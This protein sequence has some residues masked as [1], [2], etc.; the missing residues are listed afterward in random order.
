MK[1]GT[2]LRLGRIAG[3]EIGLD[4][5]LLIIFFL[6]TFSLA[7]AV[8]PVWHPA[9]SAA[10][11]W[12]T[13]LAAA[14][15]FFASVLAHELSHALMGRRFGMQIRR[16]TL[17][18][19]GGM[20]HLE[21]EPPTWRAEMAMALVGPLTSL[22]L[23]AV[24]ILLGGTLAGSVNLDATPE[25]AL[26]A[27]DPLPTLLL[28]LGPVNIILGLFNLVP[29]FP[30][31][32]GRALRAALW[33]VTGSLRRATRWA[34][35]GGRAFAW[36]LI[37]AGVAM[38]LGIELPLFGTGL[39]GGLWLAFIGWFLHNAA[40]TSYRQLLLRESLDDVPVSR[41]ML[42][43]LVSVPPS[44]DLDSLIEREAAG[45]GQ[46]AFPV[47]EGGR[48]VGLISLSD[49]QPHPRVEWPRI[50]VADA[51]TPR[52]RLVTLAPDHDA[53]EAMEQLAAR[54]LN[55]LPVVEGDALVGMV[56][57]EDV[58]RWLAL[59]RDSSAR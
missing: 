33:G 46:R 29:G 44:L 9:W 21:D 26:A 32:G 54:N 49:L 13:A 7:T 19:F 27:L 16:I 8:F 57:R 58:L 56:R 42:R 31:D 35:V 4:W 2:G 50:R 43:R 1:T 18:I 55:Q 47:V 23:G 40:L 41:L 39:V 36:L 3:I 15:L 25:R 38:M 53:F 5:S 51:M 6:I 34:S 11:V 48:L 30:L 59:H 17:F 12:L 28:W 24:F 10:T 37:A 45:S 22:V 14:V 52:A 20:A